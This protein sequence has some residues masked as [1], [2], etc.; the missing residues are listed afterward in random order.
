M[1]SICTHASKSTAVPFRKW[2]VL[3]SESMTTSL[4]TY[5]TNN[6]KTGNG[7][8]G[9]AVWTGKGR[10]RRSVVIVRRVSAPGLPSTIM[11]ARK[12]VKNPSTFMLRTS[13]F[14]LFWR[15]IPSYVLFSFRCSD[16]GGRTKEA[17]WVASRCPFS[18]LDS[19]LILSYISPS[20]NMFS[21]PL[22]AWFGWVDGVL[23]ARLPCLSSLVLP[24]TTPTPPPA[25]IRSRRCQ[26]RC[27]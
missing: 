8:T 20:P 1:K 26:P 10:K 7:S 21:S 24:L 5:S 13:C 6:E 18:S 25:L 16:Q 11:R 19:I 15:Q 9:N 23:I 12:R 3:A 17:G 22:P 27:P 4:V 14:T 2:M